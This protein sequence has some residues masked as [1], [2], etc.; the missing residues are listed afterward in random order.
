MSADALIETFNSLTTEEKIALALAVLVLLWLLWMLLRLLF[1][2]SQDLFGDGSSN[3]SGNGS[4]SNSDQGDLADAYEAAEQRRRQERTSKADALEAILLNGDPLLQEYLSQKTGLSHGEL[5]DVSKDRD[6]VL[7]IARKLDL[8][9]LKV[10]QT[11]SQAQSIDVKV[12]S[13]TKHE[14]AIHPTSD[15]EPEVLT[16]FSQLPD[17]LPEYQAQDDDVFYGQLAA[18]EVL[19]MQSYQTTQ[20]K[21]V[22]YLLLDVSGSMAEPTYGSNEPKRIWGSGVVV[23]HLVN[24]YN[25]NSICLLRFFDGGVHDLIEVRTKEEALAAIE[26]VL[27]NAFSGD[28]T[29]IYGAF[30][31]AVQDIRTQDGDFSKAEIVLITDAEDSS[32]DDARQVRKLKGDDIRLHAAV[33]GN[34]SP[35]LE[36]VS[37]S[38]REYP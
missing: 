30:K 9:T 2:L 14:K 26:I 4:G 38:Y 1:Q 6:K 12:E 37:D 28:G 16:D 22:L 31:K 8:N 19:V 20:D 7:E 34:S 36:K 17:V 3:G 13:T 35:T 23:R 21:Q 25:G 15:I 11:A 27:K 33:I 18:G 29:H 32:M 10:L 5:Q 24:A